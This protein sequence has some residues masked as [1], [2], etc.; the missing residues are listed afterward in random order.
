MKIIEKT[1]SLEDKNAP[2]I[3]VP[4]SDIHLGANG[5]NKEYFKNTINWIK[6]K[7][8]CYA[9]GV[10]DYC[11]CIVMNDKRFDIKDV[12]KDFLK[13]LDNLPMAQL[14]YLK[15]CLEPIKDRIL[16]MIPGNHEDKF[17]IEHSIDI[18]YELRRDLKIDIG[19]YMSFLRIKFDR[20]QFHVTP[21]VLWLHHGWFSGRKM[22]GKVN[23]L[24]DV[25]ASYG[26]DIYLSGHSH[27]LFSTSMEKLSI[28]VTGKQLVKSKKVFGNTGTFLETVSSGGSGYAERKAYPVAKIG[29]LRFDIYPN[30]RP[31]PDIHVRV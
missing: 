12:D 23:Q 19:D 3:L 20:E 1:I 4:F 15:R 11:D 2:L 13:D 16:C 14:N 21:I 10:G 5:C 31:R 22:G 24:N 28:G 17:R 6:N 26:A 18:M 25:A 27:D 29:T 8:N 9:I 7:P 30:H